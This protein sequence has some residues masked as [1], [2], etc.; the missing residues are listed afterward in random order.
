MVGV[1][2]AFHVLSLIMQKRYR[3]FFL[4]A[5]IAALVLC[6][7]GC[8]TSNTTVQSQEVSNIAWLPNESN[9]LVAYIDKLYLNADGSTSEGVN[10]YQ[11]NSSGS[12]G[13]AMFPSDAT[14]DG[15][16]W[17]APIVYITPNG[18]TAITQY[19]TDIYTIPV[20]GGNTN[21]LIQNTSIFGVSLDGNYIETSQS[22]APPA[23][24]ILT[25]YDVANNPPT[26]V[27]VDGMPR[28]TVPGLLSNRALWLN[29]DQYVLTIFDS[30]GSDGVDFD[31]IAIYNTQV[32]TPALIIPNGD[33][34]FSA[35]AYSPD[36]NEIFF[37]THAKGIDCFNLTTMVRT[38]IIDTDTV[39]SMDVSPDGTFLVYSSN[40]TNNNN[41]LPAYVVNLSNLHTKQF[42]TGVIL[43]KISPQSGHVAWVNQVDGSNSNVSHSG[44]A[45]A[46]KESAFGMI[47]F[48][49][50]V[51]L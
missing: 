26:I 8:D 42:A 31:H 36:S 35:A 48:F 25:I 41:T 1:N 12:I 51:R 50:Q 32:G 44:A 22:T 40:A 27:N 6:I 45:S 10:L 30:T 47:S 4:L 23:A 3:S 9:G 16:Y 19:G 18:Q 21:D 38:S 17:N 20:S 29:K 15:N 49:R 46:I 13:N 11:V 39:Y 28:K 34:S 24:S 14:P 33:V 37:R 2:S 5:G 43:P 7:A